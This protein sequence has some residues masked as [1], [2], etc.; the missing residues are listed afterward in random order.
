MPM[1]KLLIQGI[2]FDAYEVI[3]RGSRKT[4]CLCNVTAETF[5]AVKQG[6]DV[7][8]DFDGDGRV[9]WNIIITKKDR[10]NNRI[11]YYLP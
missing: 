8:V 9:I 6:D 7:Q 2:H 11:Y 5:Y 1:A 4:E 3:E 10:K